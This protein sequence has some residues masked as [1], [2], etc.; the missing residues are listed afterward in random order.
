VDLNDKGPFT[1]ALREIVGAYDH[2]LRHPVGT[3]ATIRTLR[4]L[5]R[6]V[7]KVDASSSAEGRQSSDQE[8]P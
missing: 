5:R 2:L 4:A 8:Q 7:S 1:R 6:E 3:E